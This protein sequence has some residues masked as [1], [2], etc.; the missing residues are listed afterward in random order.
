LKNTKLGTISTH[1][2]ENFLILGFDKKWLSIND[3]KPIEFE[4][5]IKD[6]KLILSGNLSRLNK[7]KEVLTNDM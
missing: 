6:G 7:T 1:F 3:E 5:E 4:I 2:F